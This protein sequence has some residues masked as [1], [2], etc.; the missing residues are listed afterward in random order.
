MRR[1]MWLLV[2]AFAVPGPVRA[3]F[4]IPG[5]DPNWPC[6]QRLV[7]DLS[8]GSYWNG[9][10]PSHTAWRDDETLFTLVTE[11]VDRDTP[12][13]EALGKLRAYVA[14]IPADKRGVALP[15]GLWGRGGE[16]HDQRSLLIQRLEQL[17]ARQRGM[18]E[19][20]ARLS[21]RI[22]AMAAA[23]PSR[24]EVTDQR[25]FDVRAFSET[26]RTMRYACEAPA[27]MERRLGEFA[28]VLRQVK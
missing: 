18:G 10:V 4:Q 28:G 11:I 16:P 8:P 15:G 26:Q 3:Q 27:N 12:D 1:Q 22:D 21:T 20:I 2:A 7:T 9:G 24:G 6:A 14:A 19:A 25:D 23:D 5:Q 17:G 13:D